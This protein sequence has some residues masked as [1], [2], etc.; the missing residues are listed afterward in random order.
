MDKLWSKS[1]ITHLKRNSD[2]Q[3]LE[4]LAERFH[5]DT[6]TVRLKIEELGLAASSSDMADQAVEDFTAGVEALFAKDSA[7]AADLFEKVIGEAE[8]RQLRD[9]AKQYLQVCR[10]R[11]ASDPPLE[12]PYLEAVGAKNRG[13]LEQALALCT[14][15]G[16][17]EGDEKF[18]YLSASVKALGEEDEEGALA[19]LARA[20]ELEPRN[21]VHAYHDPDF[22]SLRGSEVFGELIKAPSASAPAPASPP[23]VSG[24]TL[25]L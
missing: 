12:N 24:M 13:D 9:R 22:D 7:K 10:D 5:T 6:E 15:H 25:G 17:V 14:E 2:R 16:D 3:S 4:E 23:S 1:E 21:R 18:A 11:L 20:I 19:D 8:G